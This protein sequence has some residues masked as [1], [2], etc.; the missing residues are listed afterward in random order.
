MPRQFTKEQVIQ[1][2]RD[3]AEKLGHAPFK[4]EWRGVPGKTSI[5]NYFGTWNN[6]LKEAG[7]EPNLHMNPTREEVIDDIKL[8][9]KNLGRPPKRAEYLEMGKYT[10][11]NRFGGWNSFIDEIGFKRMMNVTK[12]NLIDSLVDVA[13]AIGRSPTYI[14][15]CK[16]SLGYSR[17]MVY[18]HYKHYDDLIRDANLPV[19]KRDVRYEGVSE[20]WLISQVCTVA[21]D[22][23]Y[24]PSAL[25]F[26]EFSKTCAGTVSYKFGSYSKFVKLA[27]LPP[28]RSFPANDG[29]I[30]HS[31]FEL[32]VDN[33]LSSIQLK[34]NV[35]VRVCK[36]RLWTCDFVVGDA[37]IECDGY[38]G[39]RRP[40]NCSEKQQEKYDYYHKH[41][42][43][44][45]I[46]FP[47]QDWQ[48]SLRRL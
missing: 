19:P 11:I 14:E 21:Q 29:H 13:D 25:E 26:T 43:N 47:N 22:L 18:K 33:F 12:Q 39:K 8:V 3:E 36:D 24:T 42:Y 45:I 40:Q 23:G 9:A 7:I 28:N 15:Y 35:Q 6:A 34:H 31:R 27:G 38:C 44:L 20:E 10:S 48:S 16:H 2:L 46:I 1:S 17:E 5:Q 32:S 30:V 41:S 4:N 37:W